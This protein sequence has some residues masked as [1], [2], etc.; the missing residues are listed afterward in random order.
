VSFCI[1]ATAI[2]NFAAAQGE[3]RQFGENIHNSHKTAYHYT[4]RKKFFFVSKARKRI[5]ERKRVA[6]APRVVFCVSKLEKTK[7]IHNCGQTKI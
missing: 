2:I 1:R 4:A 5:K 3:R 7:A 6:V